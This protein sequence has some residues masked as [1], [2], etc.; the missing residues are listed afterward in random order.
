LCYYDRAINISPV[1]PYLEITDYL[2]VNPELKNNALKTLSYFD[3]FNFADKIKSRIL[4]SVGIEDTCCPPSTVFATY[5]HIKSKK[6]I[7]IYDF[8]GHEWRDFLIEQTFIYI[9]KHL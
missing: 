8:M 6:D 3:A 7:S 5:N 2:K 9:R 4:V 1:Y